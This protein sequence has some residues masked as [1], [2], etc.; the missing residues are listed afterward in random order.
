MSTN[1]Y[2]LTEMKIQLWWLG[3][4]VSASH[5]DESRSLL[6]RWIESH[7][8]HVFSNVAIIIKLITRCNGPTIYAI[9]LWYN[10]PKLKFQLFGQQKTSTF[11]KTKKN[12]LKKPNTTSNPAVVAWFVR[13]SVSHLVVSLLDRDCEILYVDLSVNNKGHLMPPN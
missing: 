9:G 4:R 1:K 12:N 8:G 6:P 7:L 11:S 10:K 2:N 5:S 3:G 13:T